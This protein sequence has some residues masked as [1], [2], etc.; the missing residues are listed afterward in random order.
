MTAPR[1]FR[2]PRIDGAG[3]RTA[4]LL[5]ALWSVP[6]LAHGPGLEPD[7]FHFWSAWSARPG[8]ALPLLA[9]IGIYYAGLDRLWRH[10]GVGRGISRRRAASFTAGLAVLAIALMSP[11]DALTASLFW[12]HMVQHMLLILAAP[13]LLVLGAPEVA[14][15]WA[16]PRAWRRRTGRIENRIA[17][18]IVGP[19]EGGG[20][21]PVVVAILATGV[22]WVWHMPQ[23]YDLA[24]ENDAVHTAEHTGFLVTAILF[25]ATVL[26]LTARERLGNG[27]RIL[28]VFAQALQGSIL[29]AVITF[30]ARPL[31]DV[32][33][34][35]PLAWGFDPLVDQQIAG[36]IMW[37]PPAVLY[38]GVSAYLFV[39]WLDAVR[40]RQEAYEA[41]TFGPPRRV[42]SEAEART[43]GQLRHGPSEG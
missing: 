30:A 31:Y 39:G 32:H 22:L 42:P 16:L 8:V 43:F 3:A 37:V 14:L 18:A 9:A 7:E 38:L 26:R 33:A 17:R 11:L 34:E 2:C 35:I 27:L 5:A 6:A 24:I 28:Y 25:W 4:A 19:V 41:R 10:A 23:L 36:L 21:G 29:G 1:R 15:L 20:A 12:V 40:V 13:P